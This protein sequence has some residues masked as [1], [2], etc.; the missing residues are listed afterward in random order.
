LL[1]ND[2]GI[3][4]Q[5]GGGNMNQSY[6]F[7]FVPLVVLI[8]SGCAQAPIST[9]FPLTAQQTIQSVSHWN[10][11]ADDVAEQIKIALTSGGAVGRSV[12]LE[13]SANTPFNDGFY[14]MLL[15]K[16]FNKG[17]RTIKDKEP[18]ALKILY[19]SQVVYHKAPLKG[20]RAGKTALLTAGVLVVREAFD[21]PWSVPGRIAAVGGALTAMD[22]LDDASP[23]YFK[24]NA[25]N[26]GFII[27]ISVMDNNHYVFRKT[28]CYYINFADSWHYQEDTKSKNIKVVN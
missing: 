19:N 25:P 28:D 23:G 12:Y 1:K 20:P 27:T 13:N 21:Q 10:V 26:T 2:N 15:T 16:L 3:L 17:V 24:K 11:I 4:S 6:K 22:L 9:S 14:D 18:T 8:I 7:M 5:T